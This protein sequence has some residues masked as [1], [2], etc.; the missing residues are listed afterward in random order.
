M[1][2]WCLTEKGNSILSYRNLDCTVQHIV[3][4]FSDSTKRDLSCIVLQSEVGQRKT[5]LNLKQEAH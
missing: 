5:L 1:K 2:I 4:S 3:I